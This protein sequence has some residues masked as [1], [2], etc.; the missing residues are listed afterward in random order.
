MTPKEAWELIRSRTD[1]GGDDVVEACEILTR[2]CSR[3]PEEMIIK[4]FQS[5]ILNRIMYEFYM[6]SGE[7]NQEEADRRWEHI[8][9]QEKA[10]TKKE[11]AFSEEYLQRFLRRLYIFL[12]D[13][14]TRS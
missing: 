4:G 6:K 13:L 8:E 5:F 7:A 3:S 9:E 11:L 1:T 14:P 2:Y 10:L 12:T